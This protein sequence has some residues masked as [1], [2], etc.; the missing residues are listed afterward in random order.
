MKTTATRMIPI[1]PEAFCGEARDERALSIKIPPKMKN[2]MAAQPGE[3]L[4]GGC[5]KYFLRLVSF[6]VCPLR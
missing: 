1:E 5:M 3:G 4:A 6:G 2:P